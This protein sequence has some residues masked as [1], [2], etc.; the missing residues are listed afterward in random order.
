MMRIGEITVDNYGFEVIDFYGSRSF[1]DYDVIIIDFDKIIFEL[2]GKSFNIKQLRHQEILVERDPKHRINDFDKYLENGRK[3]IIITPYNYTI[4]FE[5]YL[6]ELKQNFNFLQFYKIENRAGKYVEIT[7]K[8]LKHIGIQNKITYTYDSYVD[9]NFEGIIEKPLAIVKDT[10]YAVSFMPDEQILFIPRITA[11]QNGNYTTFFKDLINCFFKDEIVKESLPDWA[12][13]F[14]N[15]EESVLI[16]ELDTFLQ[17]KKNIEEKIDL[18]AIKIEKQFELKRLFTATGNELENIVLDVFEKMGFEELLSEA[19]RHDL[20]LKY[21]DK[22]IVFEI[23]GVSKS[24]AET[25]ATQ[26]EK[27]VSIYHADEEELPKGVLVVNAFKD[28]PLDKRTEPV[29]PHQMISFSTKKEHCLIS[30]L[31]LYG[32]YL[33]YLESDEKEKLIDELIQTIGVYGKF[34]DYKDFLNYNEKE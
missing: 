30:G 20:I 9:F 1:L 14:T 24:A 34:K 6:H 23:K 29:F 19:N 27:W 7:N 25:Y 12:S 10:N 21:K 4:E 32:L 18:V 2:Y 5:E 28:L 31:Q 11:E 22:V 13:D 15:K 26:L 8:N 17:E 16:S 33:A 3:L